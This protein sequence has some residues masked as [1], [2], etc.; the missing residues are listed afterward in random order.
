[1]WSNC[2]PMEWAAT[3]LQNQFLPLK[4]EYRGRLTFNDVTK[5]GF[6]IRRQYDYPE[7]LPVPPELADDDGH[8]PYTIYIA[9]F[10]LEKDIAPGKLREEHVEKLKNHS[11]LDEKCVATFG[12]EF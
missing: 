5:N 6:Y 9:N 12:F 8:T 7:N 4:F 2:E 3:A 10:V 1:M 11:I